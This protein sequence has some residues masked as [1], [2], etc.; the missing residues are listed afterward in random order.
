MELNLKCLLKSKGSRTDRP[1]LKKNKVEY[2]YLPDI[3]IF[4]KLQKLRQYGT[5][6]GRKE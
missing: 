2:N 1:I 3:M 5:D 4:L 6:T